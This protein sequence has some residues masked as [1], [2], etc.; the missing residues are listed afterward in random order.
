MPGFR[1][2]GK[3]YFITFPQCD[4]SLADMRD[5]L[6]D[7]EGDRINWMVLAREL[8]QDGNP[9]LHIQIEF[10]NSK[11]VKRQDYFDFRGFHPNMQISR[12]MKRVCF[13]LI[14]V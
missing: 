7:L 5:H 2:S 11:S 12:S 4:V 10:C 1:L 13:L 6:L 8:H 3:N 14:L 9:H